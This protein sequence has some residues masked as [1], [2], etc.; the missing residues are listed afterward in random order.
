M[1]YIADS[2]GSLHGKKLD[3]LIDKFRKSCDEWDK[4][5]GF[6]PHNNLGLIF[7]YNTRKSLE[8]VLILLTE[9]LPV[10]VGW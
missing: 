6:H 1:I 8:V 9:Q 3:Y 7:K 10:W 5:L 4:W 2:L